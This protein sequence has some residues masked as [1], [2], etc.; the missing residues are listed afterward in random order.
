M[1]KAALWAGMRLMFAVEV[2]LRSGGL[3]CDH[4][5]FAARSTGRNE[6]QP[7]RERQGGAIPAA[8]SVGLMT[9]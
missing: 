6:A 7:R 4:L 3:V 5:H 8:K 9:V 2:M 1:Q